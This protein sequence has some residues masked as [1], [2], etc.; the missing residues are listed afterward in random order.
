MQ[1]K[2]E[3]EHCAAWHTVIPRNAIC[4][5][6]QRRGSGRAGQRAAPPPTR[7]WGRRR[8]RA[9]APGSARGQSR[10]GAGAAR[11]SAPGGGEPLSRQ[12]WCVPQR[13]RQSSPQ[14]LSLRQLYYLG[15]IA[16][17]APSA[18]R[19]GRATSGWTVLLGQ[20][21]LTPFSYAA[22][23]SLFAAL[24]CTA[25]CISKD[26]GDQ[27]RALGHKSFR[28]ASVCSTVRPLVIPHRCASLPRADGTTT[29]HAITN[30]AI[31]NREQHEAAKR[32]RATCC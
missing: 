16:G 6:Q 5:S 30:R 27:G 21:S 14:P 26:A 18:C 12:R 4:Q 11:S 10:S 7:R 9:A 8:G 13:A 3:C 31:T 22:V 2:L 17:R 15:V 32:C 24:L 19:Q 29:C 28:S 25:V 20:A 23:P 1:L